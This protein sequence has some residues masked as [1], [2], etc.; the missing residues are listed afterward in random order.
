MCSP[1]A[2]TAVDRSEA[3][4]DPQSCARGPRPE[5]AQADGALGQRPRPA[6]AFLASSVSAQAPIE[7]TP[8]RSLFRPYSGADATEGSMNEARLLR[9][10]WRYVRQASAHVP[11]FLLCARVIHRLGTKCQ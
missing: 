1:P 6:C 7:K 11:R 4:G 9:R 2:L 10:D 5:G 8:A 3:K